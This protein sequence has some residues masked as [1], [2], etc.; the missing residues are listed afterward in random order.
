MTKENLQNRLVNK[1]SEFETKYEVEEVQLEKF[2]TT[3]QESSRH[4]EVHH[5]DGRD[6]FY[7]KGADFIRHRLCNEDQEL[8]IKKRLDDDLTHRIEVNLNV[9]ITDEE[10]TSKFVELLGYKYDFTIF[11][12]AVVYNFSDAALS[13]YRVNSKDHSKPRCFVEIE[14]YNNMKDLDEKKAW[15]IIKKYEKML[16]DIGVQEAARLNKSL[17]EMYKPEGVSNDLAKSA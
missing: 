10:I 6:D 11:K 3:L 14:V 8:T 4:Y 7:T 1:F 2:G 12:T 13:F 15:R 5:Y 16:Y 9:G 17:Y